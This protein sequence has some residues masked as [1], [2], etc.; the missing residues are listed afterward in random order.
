MAA[1]ANTL[2]Q[3]AFLHV[4]FV[5]VIGLLATKTVIRKFVEEDSKNF[6]YKMMR[7]RLHWQ[8]GQSIYA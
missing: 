2:S 6:G 7:K 8:K 5:I 1:F 3:L 4:S